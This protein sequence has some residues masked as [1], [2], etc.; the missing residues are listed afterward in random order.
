MPRRWTATGSECLES[1]SP[2]DRLEAYPTSGDGPSLEEL[3]LLVENLHFQQQ[4]GLCQ[5]RYQPGRPSCSSTCCRAGTRRHEPPHEST[6][7]GTKPDPRDRTTLYLPGGSLEQFET[8][9]GADVF[10]Q[11]YPISPRS[12]DAAQGH[13][14]VRQRESGLGI[15][16]VVGGTTTS[17]RR[18]AWHAFSSAVPLY[19]VSAEPVAQSEDDCWRFH[20]S[21]PR[22][23]SSRGPPLCL[24]RHHRATRWHPPRL[25]VSK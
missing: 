18:T 7:P 9:M 8:L 21:P 11:L 19:A 14:R 6:L 10:E 2:T 16:T 15:S 22:R 3:E 23:R 25:A 12:T 20:F 5:Q 24:V 13:A 1:R 4:F 17:A